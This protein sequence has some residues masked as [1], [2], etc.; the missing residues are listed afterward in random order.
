MEGLRK[1]AVSNEFRGLSE[2][3]LLPSQATGRHEDHNQQN[4]EE[5]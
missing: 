5:S 2:K 3:G 1:P 4:R